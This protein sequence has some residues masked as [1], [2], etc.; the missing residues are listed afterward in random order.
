MRDPGYFIAIWT[1]TFESRGGFGRAK[2]WQPFIPYPFQVAW[3]R[4]F[5][6][7]LDLAEVGDEP[8][9]GPNSKAR[10]MG[11]SNTAMDCVLW[12]FLFVPNFTTKL[13]S[14]KED[15]VD[16]ASLD[17]LMAR[18]TA[19]FDHKRGQPAGN[20]LALPR[21]HWP[22]GF[23]CGVHKQHLILRN[24]EN[25]N[26]INGEST[27]AT[28]GRGGRATLAIVDE[29]S[30][31]PNLKHVL[32]SMT[33]TVAAALL[34]SSES[35]EVGTDFMDIVSEA[36]QSGDPKLLETDW[37]MHPHYT[38]RWLEVQR[39]K[40]EDA[41]NLPAFYREI[42][43]DAGAGLTAWAYPKSRLPHV[44]VGDFP[45][46]PGSPVW[47]G[48]DPGYDDETAITLLCRDL[49]TGRYRLFAAYA[50]SGQEPEFYASLLS[51]VADPRFDYGATEAALMEMMRRL[52]TPEALYG[53][54]NGASRATGSSSWYIKMKLWWDETPGARQIPIITSWKMTKGDAGRSLQGRRT[55]LMGL[56]DRLDFND[57]PQG[58]VKETLRSIQ[59]QKW[60]VSERRSA[61]QRTPKHDH[62][63][64][65]RTSAMEYFAVN[66]EFAPID[67]ADDRKRLLDAVG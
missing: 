46:V 3:V 67:G 27:N 29:A 7:I 66:R 5:E 48:F 30:F 36:K 16:S 54:P 39:Q 8:A 1:A 63:W 50:N 57:D 37:W 24:P 61:E 40:Y 53:D 45:Y 59:N 10:T 43:R 35:V 34:I 47:V 49:L 19:Q 17:S 41:G 65:H 60:D 13:V 12:A 4:W 56:L 23:D 31:I 9:I 20:P 6:R 21:W 32:G 2:G 14:R 38:A 22:E 15:L 25:G 55:A 18:I 62:R 51:G 42:L 64:T 11:V 33:E 28:T 44:G 58:Q 52:P 26:E